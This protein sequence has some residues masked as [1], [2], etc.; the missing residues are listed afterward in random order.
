MADSSQKLKIDIY[1]HLAR[2]GKS[3]SSPRRLHIIDL[4]CEGPRTVEKLAK[5]TGMTVANTSQHLQ[6]LLESRLVE[7]EKQG[8]YS[9]YQLS[10]PTVGILFHHMQVL[11][12]NLITDI[13]KL[14]DDVYGEHGEIEQVKPDQLMEKLQKG[15]VTLIDV[16]P[17]EYYDADH[18]Q[19]AT[20]IPLEELEKHL[21]KLPPDQ[22]IIAYCRGRYC[23]LSV[24]AVAI[25]NKHGYRA[26]R[27][28][29]D[30]ISREQRESMS[31]AV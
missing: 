18:I 11:G 13:Q 31:D 27:L 1:S 28:E 30:C 8:L 5:E 23:L 26:V 25:L 3:L 6:T 2:V 4:L 12:E 19:G 9:V 15:K 20:S 24:E 17:K 10:D 7:F 21:E 14:L 16:R 29:D 22:E